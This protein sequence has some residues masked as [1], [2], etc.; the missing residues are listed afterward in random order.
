MNKI[1][2]ILLLLLITFS[3]DSTAQEPIK[4]ACIGNSITYGSGVVNR[5]KNAYPAQLQELLGDKYIV[6]NYGVS[7]RTLL[8]K[9]DHPYW[10]TE[11]YKKALE[12]KP[13]VVFIKLGTNDSKLQNRIHLDEFENNY[14]ELINSFKKKNG[15]T[16]I[17]LLLPVPAFTKD[18]MRIW[19]PV[20]KNKI[21]PM[22]Q[23]V[24]FKANVEIIDL[25]Q[26][27]IDK[28]HLI[29][30]GVHP[31]SLGQSVIA[32]RLFGVIKQEQNKPINLF[33]SKELKTD[34]TENFYGYSVIN[35]K[36]DSVLCKI[37]TPKKIAKGT[38][39]VLRARFW[40]H[41]PQT[42]ISLLERGFHIAYCDVGNLYG[43]REAVER[44]NDFYQL[45]IGLGLS[46]KVVLEGMSRGGLI[47]YNWAAEN[48][49]KVAAI[50]ADAPVLD[51]KS[52]PGG[53][54]V[55][56]G[57]PNDWE[58]FKKMYDIK[59]ESNLDTFKGNP[60]HKINEIA[61]AGFPMF[62]VV[63]ETDKV[64]PISEN[65]V[66]FEKG[67]TSLGGNIEVIYKPNNGHHPHS[68]QNPT[69]IVDF[70]LRATN[71]KINFAVIP[72]PSAEYRS[73][74]GWTNGTDWRVQAKD[75]DSMTQSLKNIDLL[76]IGNSITQS[77][78]GNS[79]NYI[80]SYGGAE[81]V[82]T[83]FKD[84]VWMNAGISGDRT[85]HILWRLQN[86]S[87]EKANPKTVVLAIGVNNFPFNNAD[88]IVSGIE[89]VMELS[90]TKFK[91]SKIMLFG[92][93]PTGIDPSSKRRQKYNKVHKL[94]SSLK[95]PNNVSY[96]NIISLFTDNSGFL[97]ENY[98]SGDGIHLKPE[99]Y[100][101]WAK[102]LKENI[103]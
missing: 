30:D 73:G 43:N 6:K 54:G 22:T 58:S 98:Y 39:W 17:V 60:I 92:P 79:R 85:E 23:S 3:L 96:H 35:F 102:Y 97:K 32:R 18:S 75:I 38:P 26:L 67:I 29:P 59:N 72:S 34:N 36:M 52:W 88:E 12:F 15:D 77:W 81:A 50:Y 68:L 51:G 49:E 5:E 1:R 14:T 4:I 63:G 82:K 61:K 86:G 95:Y 13:D 42:D 44:W 19:D 25:Y 24:A 87:Y 33:D 7:G 20:I 37:V 53:K 90:S 47:V 78:G 46:K 103:K 65:T 71:Q 62:H 66:P 80:N 10:E 28:E 83:Y 31:S 27:F 11:A 69:P 101:I 2:F 41:E 55:G 70:I 56:K 91:N 45:M 93:L 16:R 48:P 74:A 76:L 84:L 21:I 57:S 64:V 99:G 89:K 94:L 40:G 100:T 8:K 9:G